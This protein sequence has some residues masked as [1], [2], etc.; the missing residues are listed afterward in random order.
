MLLWNDIVPPKESTFY[1]AQKTVFKPLEEPA[2]HSLA[3]TQ[4][5]LLAGTVIS[6]DG[7]WSHRRDAKECIVVAIVVGTNKI[8]DFEIIR[9]AKNGDP[10][11]YD[12]SSNGMEVEALT[13]I[14]ARLKSDTRIVGYVHDNDS[15]ASKAIRDAG[16]NIREYFDPNHISI[17]YERKWRK[18]KKSALNGL[19]D[20]SKGGSTF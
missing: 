8:L 9:R 5:S 13:H 17:S 16:W 20:A 10:G 2:R 6:L 7:S 3:I 18:V 14:I 12:G 15:K 19:G 11:N 4:A 1:R